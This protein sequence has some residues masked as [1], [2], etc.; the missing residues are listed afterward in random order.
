MGAWRQARGIAASAARG[1]LAGAALYLAADYGSELYTFFAVRRAALERAAASAELAALLGG[2]PAPAPWYDGTL[3]FS[4]ADRVA[5]VTF[6]VVGPARGTDVVARAARRP[7]PR[8]VRLYNAF[9]A[10]AWD[11]VTCSAMFPGAGGLAVPRS[12]MEPLPAVAAKAAAEAAVRGGGG[13]GECLPCQEQAAA[14]QQQG[15]W[16]RG[17]AAAGAGPSGAA[18]AQQAEQQQEASSGGRRWWWW[19]GG[20]TGGGGSIEAG[21]SSSGGAGSGGGPAAASSPGGSSRG[22]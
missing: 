21:G 15:G 6:G 22:A 10:G 9:G 1:A 7:G 14:Q 8:D 2:P 19:G 13:G 3:A 11:L 17:G 4:R 16:R 18:Q 12:L 20:K 5:H